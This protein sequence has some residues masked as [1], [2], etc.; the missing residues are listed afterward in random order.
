[1]RGQRRR[2]RRAGE[3]F[4]LGCGRQRPAAE[5]EDNAPETEA[6]GL[7]DMDFEGFTLT[8]F[9]S[10]AYF[11]EYGVW[12]GELTGETVSDAI[13]NRNKYLEETYNCN[14]ELLETSENHTSEA[15]AKYVASGDDTVDVL[16]DGGE[17]IGANA[18]NFRDLNTLEYFDF[19]KPWWNKEFNSGVT[20]GGRLYF[21]VGCY[22]TTALGG[23]RH[24]VFNKSVAED[25]GIDGQGYYGLVR[26]GKWVIDR[27]TEDA[28]KVK[29]DLNG[30]GIYDTND[31]WGVVGENYVTWSLAL[32]CGFRCAGKD[33]GDMPVISFGSETNVSIMDKVLGLTGDN[34]TV[35]FAQR[36]TGVDDKW[37]EY[38]KMVSSGR[39]WLFTAAGLLDTMR[40]M[41]EDY[42]VLPSPKFDESQDRYY[43]DASLG[44]SPTTGIPVSASDP[45][46]VSYLMEAM[47]WA[48][49]NQVIPEFYE[50]YLNT[51]M[52][53][54]EESVE[55]LKIIHNSLYYD[56]GA[57][58]NW[59]DMRMMIEGMTENNL[60]SK[61][62]RSEKSINKALG[63]T[64][65]AFGLN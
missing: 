7:P 12:S 64:L 20:I 63:K 29:S 13:F 45:D 25:F 43:H 58:Y 16:F 4:R 49:Y 48:S 60:A 24:I 33:E 39:Q 46:T 31:L 9:R 8:L 26:D 19:S 17:Y 3:R 5:A 36:L 22:Q 40:S 23:I 21:T 54:D 57:L 27:M 42:G 61:Y 62:A 53:R 38:F 51:K 14:I 32:G 44:L 52:V 11:P 41:E 15:V 35:I 10:A 59:G 34:D 18:A 65:E 30:D 37:T 2:Y 56:I 55:M 1:M 50:N 47:C 6:S 28:R